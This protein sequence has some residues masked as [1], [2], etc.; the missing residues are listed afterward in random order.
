M[1]TIV[2]LALYD[3]APEMAD[4]PFVFYTGVGKVNAA[5]KA[6]V[7]IER[8]RPQHVI[9]FGTAGG[10][11]QPTGFYETTRFVQRDMLCESLGFGPGQ[12]PYETNAVIE[13]APGLTCSTGDDFVENP[14][15]AIP[16]DLVDMEAYA[17][18]KVCQSARVQFSCYKFVTDAANTT[19]ADEWGNRV[20]HGQTHYLLKLRE[21][22]LY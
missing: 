15:L 14:S 12:T 7:L 16:A 6:A 1:K 13:F 9:N 4:L 5:A 10:I 20:V 17:I 8:H 3:E 18:A 11:T 22:G 2:L 21:L 19:A